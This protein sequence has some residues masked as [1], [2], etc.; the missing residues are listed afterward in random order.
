MNGAALAAR[1][2]GSLCG[3]AGP[4][5]REVFEDFFEVFL[6]PYLPVVTPP[7]EGLVSLRIDRPRDGLARLLVAFHF[8]NQAITTPRNRLDEARM[9]SVTAQCLAQ[10]P[11]RR[12]QAVFEFH[13]GIG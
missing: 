11:H 1:F 12:V 7:Q 2:V 9:I 3:A 4:C 6:R 13:N 5:L 10:P 8:D